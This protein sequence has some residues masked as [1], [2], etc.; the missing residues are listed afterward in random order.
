MPEVVREPAV[1]KSAKSEKAEAEQA[2]QEMAEHI[3]AGMAQEPP[4]TTTPLWTCS[5]RGRGSWG[6]RPW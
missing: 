6:E 3:Q 2:A 4:P 5:K 1:P